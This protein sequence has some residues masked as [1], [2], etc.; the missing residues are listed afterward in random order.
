MGKFKKNAATER[1]RER[2][3]ERKEERG[4]GRRRTARSSGTAGGIWRP[5]TA[6]ALLVSIIY[7]MTRGGWKGGR[8]RDDGVDNKS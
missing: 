2:G 1:K 6:T 8:V 5:C 3:G 4:R 7:G